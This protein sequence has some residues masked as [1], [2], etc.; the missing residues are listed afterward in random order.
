MCASLAPG[1]TTMNLGI[2]ASHDGRTLRA[3]LDA[4]DAGTLPARVCV[5][6]SNNRGSGALKQALQAGIAHAHLSARTHED[7]DELDYVT[8]NCLV[9]AKAELVFLAG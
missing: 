3:I 9:A 5:V 7:P 6:I 4:C 8:A 1:G 2:L